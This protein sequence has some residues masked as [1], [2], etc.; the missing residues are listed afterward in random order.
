[1]VLSQNMFREPA[2]F[3]KSSGCHFVG[4]SVVCHSARKS[5][6]CFSIQLSVSLTVT[7]DFADTRLA[8]QN[9]AARTIAPN[10]IRFL[11]CAT[12]PISQGVTVAARLV[13]GFFG[14]IGG[15]A[16]GRDAAL[17]RTPWR[18]RRPWIAPLNEGVSRR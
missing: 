1:M 14:A 9:A 10:F 5:A 8:Q 3:L 6:R 17:A 2:K 4:P 7:S 16:P 12:G 15:Q 18:W 11:M 13:T